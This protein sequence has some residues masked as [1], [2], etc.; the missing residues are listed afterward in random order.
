VKTDAFTIRCS[1]MSTRLQGAL[2]FVEERAST[3][4]MEPSDVRDGLV[5]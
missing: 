4:L 3:R 5:R 2:D 1:K